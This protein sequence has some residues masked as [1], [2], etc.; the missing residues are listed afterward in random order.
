MTPLRVVVVGGGIAGLAAAHRLVELARDERV[1]RSTSSSSR[2]PAGWAGRSAPSGP[3]ASCSRPGPTR[4]SPRSR[5]PWP[6]PSASGLGPR[7]RRTDDRFRRTY[8]VRGG[9]LRPLPE[10]FLLLAPTR[11]SARAR[12][13]ASSPGAGSSGS[14][15]TWCCRAG[16][17]GRGREPRELRPAPARAGGARA[18]RPAARRRDLHGGSRTGCRLAATMPR[19]LALEREH[20]SLILGLRRTARARRRPGASGARWSLFVTLAG[21]MEE[22]VTALAARLPHGAARVGTPV[23]AVELAPGRLAGPS[24]A[25]GRRSRRTAS[26]S[27]GR[28]PD[29]GARRAVDPRLAGLLDGI[30]Y[31]SSATVALAY[32]RARSGI[33][34]TASASWCRGW[35]G[36]RRSPARS[37][38]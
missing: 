30:A 11:A 17:R 25:T 2:R 18:G 36:G 34:S 15:S 33:R 20:R 26:C 12:R 27:P 37:R 29:G 16:P 22:L 19:F 14:G 8:V 5:G 7:L 32:P 38:A 10:G 31:V 3:T 21:G 6:W 13:P 24:W 4:S 28:R 9:R 23:T 35:R 1:G